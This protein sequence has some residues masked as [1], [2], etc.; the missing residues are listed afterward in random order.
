MFKFTLKEVYVK[1]Y[2][3]CGNSVFIFLFVYGLEIF[4]D[5]DHTLFHS[6]SISIFGVSDKSLLLKK[7]LIKTIK[8]NLHLG[9]KLCQTWTTFIKK[10][11]RKLGKNVNTEVIFILIF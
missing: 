3:F 11:F 6:L 7:C 1:L 8:D 10:E 5:G 4:L 2:Q 9:S